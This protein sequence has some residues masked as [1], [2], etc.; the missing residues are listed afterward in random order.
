MVF[1][2]PPQGQPLQ[3]RRREPAPSSHRARPAGLGRTNPGCGPRPARLVAPS[4][5]NAVTG[6]A[7][8]ESGSEK[9]IDAG[10][11]SSQGRTLTEVAKW[12]GWAATLKG[13]ARLSLYPPHCKGKLLSSALL[14]T[15]TDRAGG[16]TILLNS[17]PPGVSDD[18]VRLSLP[19]DFRCR[20]LVRTVICASDKPAVS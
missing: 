19:P 8:W 17:A 9:A 5:L 3:S 2:Q 18:P 15:P 4:A 13:R 1:P 10:A 7:S 16:P 14:L 20:L 12:G 6:R 11:G